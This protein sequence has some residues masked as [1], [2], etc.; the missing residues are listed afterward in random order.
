[1]DWLLEARA[2]TKSFTG[3]Q[4]LNG[5]SLT[6]RDGE[7]HAVVGG[8]GAGKSTLMKLLA[9]LEPPDSGELWLNGAPVRFRGPSDALRRGIAMIHQELLPF[10]DLPVA[11]NIF[12]GQGLAPRLLGWVDQRSLNRRSSLLL[13]RLAVPVSPRQRMGNLRVAEMQGVEIAKALAHE[14]RLIIMDEPTSAL[15]E[16]EAEALFRIISDLRAQGVALL[17]ISH[18]LS[19]VFQ[20]ADRVTVLRD[21]SSEGTYQANELT[22][23]NL[24]AL[25]VGRDLDLAAPSRPS[26]RGAPLLSVKDLTKSGRFRG[27]SFEVAAGEILGLGGL[28]G[29]GRTDVVNAIYGLEPA[30]SGE[31]R[32]A[33]RPMRITRPRDALRAGIGLVSEDRKI[34]GL[35]PSFG[36]R[37]NVSLAALR[38]YCRG[39][40]V[41]RR[42]EQRVADEQI[43]RLGIRARHRDQPV[44]HLS[45]GNQQKV[46]LAR[47]LL[48]E[49]SILLLDEPT[50]GIDIAAKA[51]VHAIVRELADFGKAIVLVSS[52]LPELFSLSHRVL[53][54]REGMV[55][56]ELDPTQAN[57]EQAFKLAL[58]E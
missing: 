51:D 42:A 32:V 36:L 30:D 44:L 12:M 23:D 2:L 52:E 43:R 39:W 9:G 28:M 40:F 46:V 45:G 25:M 17:Y 26:H 18:K 24:I 5:V 47:T 48:T 34:F 16:R 8:N 37:S 1:M 29:A 11:E 57:P 6:V 31:I 38:R 33:G 20:L 14:A 15:S 56:G 4:V 27:V 41:D 55:A 21:G 35:V 7:V 50:R 49:P 58:P 13:E 3:V 22:A 54:M 19:E 10:P 53:M